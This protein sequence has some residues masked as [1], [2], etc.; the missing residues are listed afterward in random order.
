[1]WSKIVRA[2][3]LLMLPGSGT[4]DRVYYYRIFSQGSGEVRRGGTEI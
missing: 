3:K 4:F 2:V 1:M